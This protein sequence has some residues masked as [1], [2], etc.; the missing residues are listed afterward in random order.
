MVPQSAVPFLYE[1]DCHMVSHYAH[2]FFYSVYFV[3][4]V[5]VLWWFF[6]FWND[7]SEW[8][9]NLQTILLKTWPDY[10]RTHKIL[11]LAFGKEALAQTETY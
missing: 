3:N 7:Q 9:M 4:I 10:G 5:Y 6:L 2:T 11:K 1:L 8:V